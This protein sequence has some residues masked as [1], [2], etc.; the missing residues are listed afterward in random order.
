MDQYKEKHRELLDSKSMQIRTYLQ[1][2]VSEILADG[3][4]AICR[5]QPDDPVDAL[6]EYLFR[7]SLRVNDPSPFSI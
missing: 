6:A 5:D 2:N 4:A 3:L 7:N 1:N